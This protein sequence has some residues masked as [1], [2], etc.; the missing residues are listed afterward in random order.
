VERAATAFAAIISVLSIPVMLLNFGGGIVGGIWLM[1]IGNWSLFGLGILSMFV[2]SFGLGLAL[3]PGLLFTGPAALLMERGRNVI[4]MAC[5]M[6]GNLYT[7]AVMTVW[8]VGCFYVVFRLYYRGGSI[9][10]YL[11]WTYGMATGPWTYMAAREGQHSI[12]SNL[13][14][15]GACIGAIA[16]MGTMLFEAH[17]TL[18]DIA[19]AFCLPLLLVVVLQ[20]GLAITAMR[21]EARGF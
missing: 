16:M 12:A 8:C 21:Q 17:P 1:V 3:A 15:F 5:A 9:W 10:P 20:F 18:P 14:A 13:S 7:F 6:L 11:L 19:I 4:G 2:S